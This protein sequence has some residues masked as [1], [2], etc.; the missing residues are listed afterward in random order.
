MPWIYKGKEINK[1]IDLPKQFQDYF[2]FIYCIK[3]NYKGENFEYSFFLLQKKKF[4]KKD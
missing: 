3:L 2:G 4:Q 1:I